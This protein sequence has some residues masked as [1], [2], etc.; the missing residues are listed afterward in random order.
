MLVVVDWN[1]CVVDAVVVD[2]L[3]L[4]SRWCTGVVDDTWKLTEEAK[5]MG[6][7][8]AVYALCV[9]PSMFVISVVSS[10]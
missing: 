10:W 8:I 4:I 9:R 2:V 6:K 5:L 7:A 1:V 3:P